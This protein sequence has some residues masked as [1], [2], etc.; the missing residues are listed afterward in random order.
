M[1]IPSGSGTTPDQTKSEEQSWW[2]FVRVEQRSKPS[3]QQSSIDHFKNNKNVMTSAA[4]AEIGALYINS[5][6]AI[7]A[8]KTVEEIG[9]NQP[10]TPIQTN[11]TT[12]LG[13]ITKNLKPIATKSADMKHWFMRDQQDRNQFR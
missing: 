8:Q 2:T 7:P 10:P 3:K 5:W 13:F 9:H 12:A 11:N 1:R 4:D 6:Q